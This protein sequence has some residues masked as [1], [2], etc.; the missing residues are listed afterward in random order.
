M[1]SDRSVFSGKVA[2]TGHLVDPL[3]DQHVDAL[4]IAAEILH[5]V[6]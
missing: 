6:E 1:I 3:A 4:E 5:M 2:R